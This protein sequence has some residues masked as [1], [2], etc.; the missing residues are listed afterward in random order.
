MDYPTDA[1]SS[2]SL[3][4][5]V[6]EDAELLAELGERTFCEAFASANRPEDI[7][8]YLPTAFGPVIQAAEL[9][10]P[11]STFL[12]AYDGEVAAGYARL[13]EKEAP[14]CVRG[15]RPIEL[16]RLY[17]LAACQS[18]GL[19]STLIGTC[20][21]LAREQGFRTL[22]LGVWER[23]SGAMRFYRRWGFE[24]VGQHHFQLGSDLQTDLLM[25][26]SLD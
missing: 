26:R 18:R 25:E 8:A 10:R 13:V 12:I 9:A 1:H 17:L 20:I 16:N 6:L 22:W 23:N 2:V 7:A 15:P 19:G 3:R 21:A 14:G 5:A 24:V 4:V 11:G